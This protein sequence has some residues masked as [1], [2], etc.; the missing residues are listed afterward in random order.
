MFSVEIIYKYK[1]KYIAKESNAGGV[2]L[3]SIKV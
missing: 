2:L 1:Y 3:T